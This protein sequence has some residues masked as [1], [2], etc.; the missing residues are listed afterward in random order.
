MLDVMYGICY[1]G[2]G[3]TG[4]QIPIS[5]FQDYVTLP[6]P[7]EV[8]TLLELVHSLPRLPLIFDLS[9]YPSVKFT[10]V[11]TN[12]KKMPLELDSRSNS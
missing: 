10:S 11:I 7:S 1:C 3:R 9:I 2:D 8:S 5:K 4:F 12:E 6:L